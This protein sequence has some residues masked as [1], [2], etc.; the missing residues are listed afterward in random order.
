MARKQ[1]RRTAYGWST[2]PSP[3]S[4]DHTVGLRRRHYVSDW[5]PI[6]LT[7]T[8]VRS[9]LIRT[10]LEIPAPPQPPPRRGSRRSPVVQVRATFRSSDRQTRSPFLNATAVTPELT[11]RAIICA[12]RT[13][14][15]EVLFANKQTGKGAKAPKRNLSK[16]R[17]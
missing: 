1:K 12:K 11:E 5:E 9:P 6:P 8:P 16:V 4:L 15:R 7:P 14:R 2:R 17:C 3:Q 13:I 10:V